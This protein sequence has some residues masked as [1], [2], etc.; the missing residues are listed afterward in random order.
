VAEYAEGDN[1][2]G[3]VRRAR[4]VEAE[5]TRLKRMGFLSFDEIA[6]HIRSVGRGQAQPIV[7]TSDISFPADYQISRQACHRAFQKALGR[8]PALEVEELR[9]LDSQRCEEMYLNLQPAIRKG[10][11]PAVAV[12]V[13]VLSHKAKINGYATPQQHELTG[14]YGNG[15]TVRRNPDPV[16]LESKVNLLRDAIKVL[17]DLEVPCVIDLPEQDFKALPADSE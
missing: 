14:K 1:C 8:E 7:A 6:E 5:S 17:R 2:I 12:G 4:W 15:V 3:K 13:K 11:P 10:H 16:E 9:K